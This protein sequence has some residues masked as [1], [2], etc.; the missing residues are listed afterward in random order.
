MDR[1]NHIQAK[2]LDE[3][4]LD[5]W[6]ARMRFKKQ[7][8]VFTNGCFDILH[9][10]HI[11]YLSKA[12]D[13][14]DAL[15]VGLNSDASVR[16]LKGLDR[17]IID[18]YSRALLLASLSFVTAIVFF[19]E[20]SPYELIRKVQPDVLIKGSDYRPEEIV[21]YDIVTAKGGEVLTI[22]IVEGFSS[23]SII[24]KIANNI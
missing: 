17:P 13:A 11:V 12:A 20:E 10:G 14:G 15:I 21:G 22:D 23:S 1:I 4:M 5:A 18:Q 19:N 8:I 16:K 9:R 24:S 2:I 3:P 7:K 6:L